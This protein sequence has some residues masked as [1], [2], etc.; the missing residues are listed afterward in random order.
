MSDYTINK[1]TH[2]PTDHAVDTAT[3]FAA[4]DAEPG[5]AL[6]A[7][8]AQSIAKDSIA[9]LGLLASA[10]FTPISIF[11]PGTFP[12]VL[13]EIGAMMYLLTWCVYF[14]MAPR[15][16]TLSTLPWNPQRILKLNQIMFFSSIPTNISLIPV[17]LF[18]AKYRLW[19]MRKSPGLITDL[20]YNAQRPSKRLDI[21]VPERLDLGCSTHSRTA[22]LSPASGLHPVVIFIYGGSWSSGSKRTYT[23]VGARL[24]EMGY[25][26]V[27]PDYTIFPLGKSREMEQDVRMA[28]H[29]TRRHCLNYGGDPDNIFLMGHSAGAHICS[30]TM[31]KESVHQ[32]LRSQRNDSHYTLEFA[33]W[34]GLATLAKETFEDATVYGEALPRLRGL[35][36]LSGVYDIV[37]HLEHERVRGVEEISAMSRVM[38]GNLQAFSMNSPTRI[39]EDLVR[40]SASVKA[41]QRNALLQRLKSF[42]PAK[43]LVIHGENDRTVPAASSIRFVSVLRALQLGP[44]YVRLRIFPEMAHQAPVVAIMP[45]Y[46]KAS[47]HAQPLIGEYRHF[48]EGAPH[49]AVV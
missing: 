41:E 31:V 4:T 8:N 26:V 6:E 3:P 42:L 39:L 18:L 34:P 46:Q 29:W 27:I 30:L 19:T 48:I 7:R 32:T 17:G 37:A 24:R 49:K 2:L 36:L 15:P 25:L 43:M 44:D 22:S 40:A 20:H 28:I 16:L 23:L 47:A 9:K 1:T 14:Q 13:L 11:L 38:G 12:L 10:L 33:A 35:I 45:S 21:H 5:R